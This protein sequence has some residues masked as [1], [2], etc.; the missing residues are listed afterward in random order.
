[1]TSHDNVSTSTQPSVCNQDIETVDKS[2]LSSKDSEKSSS[3]SSGGVSPT[4]DDVT[5][6]T[7]ETNQSNLSK[8]VSPAHSTQEEEKPDNPI[9]SAPILTKRTPA[10][11]KDLEKTARSQESQSHDAQA[12]HQP[13]QDQS[14]P[15]LT[16][17]AHA[18]KVDAK[19]TGGKGQLV[20]GREVVCILLAVVM[21]VMLAYDWLT[22][23]IGQVRHIL[24]AGVMDSL[25]KCTLEYGRPLPSQLPHT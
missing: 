23:Y 6:A 2:I 1:M 8:D 18:T 13:V 15:T 25:V 22:E 9:S 10:V 19:R 16:P 5:V 3:E 24:A 14:A 12:N 4:Q 20:S 7:K 11:T 17:E 21:R